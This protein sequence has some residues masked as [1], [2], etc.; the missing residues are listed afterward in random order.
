MVAKKVVKKIIKKDANDIKKILK[1][2]ANTIKKILKNDSAKK[3]EKKLDPTTA[4]ECLYCHNPIQELDHQVILTGCNNGKITDESY[5]HFLCWKE[6][7]NKQVLEK[8]K[9]NVAVMQKRVV[10]ILENPMLKGI[11]S[12]VKGSEGLFGMLQMPMGD[13]DVVADAVKKVEEK[14]EDDRKKRKDAKTQM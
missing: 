1:K 6:N 14:I 10:G 3:K 7:F 5:F 8:A 11:L 2:D 12:Q 4:F 13:E 9:K